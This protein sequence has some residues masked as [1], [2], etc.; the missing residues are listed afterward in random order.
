MTSDSRDE[1]TQTVTQLTQGDRSAAEKLFSLV[2]DEFRKMARHFM[3]Q[4]GPDVTLEPTAL[5]HEAFLRLVNQDRVEWQGKTHFFAV[6][7]QIMRRLLVDHARSR[8]RLKR[9]GGRTRL[10]LNED[11]ALADEREAD[12]L[13][14]E[15]A[16][17]KLSELDE[18]QARIVEMRYYGGLTV[19]QVAEVLGVSK[20]TVE[21]DWTVAR[22][23][24]KRE[25]SEGNTS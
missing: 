22:A 12:V 1:I 14:L 17:E 23:W 25:L 21:G 13:A 11:I 9:G 5:V 24:L 10:A 3:K 4:E 2:Y 16:L 18:R 15:E 20:R 6:G 8:K 7:A 19:A